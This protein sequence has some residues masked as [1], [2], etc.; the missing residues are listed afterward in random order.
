MGCTRSPFSGGFRCCAFCTGPVNP[1][2][3]RLRQMASPKPTI[4]LLPGMNSHYPVYSRLLPLVENVKVVD[5]IE[6]EPRESLPS[7]AERMSCYFDTAAYIGGV[8]FGGIL[9]QEISRIIKPRGC[10]LISTIVGPH[11]LPPSV[12]GFRAIGRRTYSNAH[13]LLCRSASFVPRRIR[14][15]ATYRI[16]RLA[17]ENGN[18]Q[19][20]A[21]GAILDWNPDVG[22]IPVPTLQIHGDA[23]RTFPINLTTPDIIVPTGRHALPVSHPEEVAAAIHRLRTAA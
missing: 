7:Y 6:P 3:M 14:T 8:S 16:G 22:S 1:D 21:T 19:R 9:A 12:R 18:W 10:L 11:Q 4:Y 13:K 2:V 23:D 5:F 20:W 17:G 15:S